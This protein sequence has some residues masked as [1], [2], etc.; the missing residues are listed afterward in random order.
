MSKWRKHNHLFFT[1]REGYRFMWRNLR[2]GNHW[3][4][5]WCQKWSFSVTKEWSLWNKVR[6]GRSVW[7]CENTANSQHSLRRQP[8]FLSIVIIFQR[9]ASK[10]WMPY[11]ALFL[12]VHSEKFRATAEFFHFYYTFDNPVEVSF[13][14]RAEKQVDWSVRSHQSPSYVPRI[15]LPLKTSL[16]PVRGELI[17]YLSLKKLPTH[18]LLAPEFYILLK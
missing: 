11:R 10:N 8:F 17:T 2:L 13:I 1:F 18:N 12:S 9:K 3:C 6:N 5:G 7:Q 15:F 4:I 16:V 14:Y